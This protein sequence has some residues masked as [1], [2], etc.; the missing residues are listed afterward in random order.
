VGHYC[1][2]LVQLGGKVDNGWYVIRV[3]ARSHDSA[4]LITVF[5]LPGFTLELLLSS[6][7][8]F[9]SKGSAGSMLASSILKEM[10]S[11]LF[12]SN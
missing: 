9:P 11:I 8:I 12:I 3:L 5:D 10:C 4:I 1:V 7:L 2:C 6:L